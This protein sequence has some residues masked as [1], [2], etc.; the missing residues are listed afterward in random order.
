MSELHKNN[1]DLWSSV[2]DMACRY[3]SHQGYIDRSKCFCKKL[4]K[5]EFSSIYEAGM[6]NGR[7]LKYIS[8]KFLG[9]KIGGCDVNK[10]ALE[11]K[12]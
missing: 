10:V 4:K 9:I 11:F 8:D 2:G 5:Y 6:C 3:W 12:K 1:I 7:N